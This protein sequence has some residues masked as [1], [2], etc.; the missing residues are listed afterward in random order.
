MLTLNTIL[1]YGRYIRVICPFFV[2][3]ELILTYQLTFFQS[4]Q[5]ATDSW[6]KKS[7]PDNV[8][9]TELRCC[10][11]FVKQRSKEIWRNEALLNFFFTDWMSQ[12]R[13]CELKHAGSTLMLMEN[14]LLSLI[15]SIQGIP[16]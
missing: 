6:I 1:T 4:N 12:D 16:P 9:L 3:L 11:S 10:P 15:S 8:L 5:N 13:T 2:L 7:L 14:G